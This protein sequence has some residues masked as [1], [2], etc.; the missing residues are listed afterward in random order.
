MTL[1]YLQALGL[2][3]DIKPGDYTVSDKDDEKQKWSIGSES[4]LNTAAKE[5]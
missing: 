2:W 1:L 5:A 3:K 4:E